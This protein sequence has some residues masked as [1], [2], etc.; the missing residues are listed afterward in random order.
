LR[1]ISRLT[2]DGDRPSAEAIDR[3]EHPA[4]TP[5]EI[6]SRSASVKA[7]RERLRAGGR[8]PPV[9]ARMFLIDVWLRPK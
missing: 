8:I 2:V 5:R 6:S 9:R 4:T 3:S 1:R 7:S